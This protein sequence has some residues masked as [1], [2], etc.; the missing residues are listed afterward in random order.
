M[1]PP[2]GER[3]EAKKGN[4]TQD[5]VGMSAKAAGQKSMREAVA[6]E[7]FRFTST[8]FLETSLRSPI[9]FTHTTDARVRS[10]PYSRGW[11][12]CRCTAGL[13][14]LLAWSVHFTLNLP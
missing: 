6:V 12:R 2:P 5:M 10:W 14:S 13:Q 9:V 3:V 4:R 8:A 7:Y 11:G 1:S